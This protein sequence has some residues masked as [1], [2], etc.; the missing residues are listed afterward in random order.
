LAYP[1]IVFRQNALES[2]R[3]FASLR[4]TQKKDHKKKRA[5]AR[6]ILSRCG[7]E[8]RRTLGRPALLRAH[9]K[10]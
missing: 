1:S 4:M 9:M 8:S 10:E 6:V 3:S 7:E 2:A 5:A